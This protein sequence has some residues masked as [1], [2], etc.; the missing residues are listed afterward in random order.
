MQLLLLISGCGGSGGHKSVWSSDK[1][2]GGGAGSFMMAWLDWN[3]IP[4]DTAGN[5][6]F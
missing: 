5:K 6:T 3:K 1:P 2:V 4:T